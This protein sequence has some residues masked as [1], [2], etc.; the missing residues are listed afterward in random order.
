[1]DKIQTPCYTCEHRKIDHFDQI[2][3]FHPRVEKAVENGVEPC[4][5]K[6]IPAIDARKILTENNECLVYEP[7]MWAKFFNRV[8]SGL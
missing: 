7:D 4:Q 2:R 5:P 1:M 6:G 3:C 8:R